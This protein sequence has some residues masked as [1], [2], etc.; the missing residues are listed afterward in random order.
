MDAVPSHTSQATSPLP[1]LPLLMLSWKPK[2]SA[3]FSLA[4]GNLLLPRVSIL[5]ARAVLRIPLE[6]FLP[7]CQADVVL[8]L[9]GTSSHEILPTP[10]VQFLLQLPWPRPSTVQKHVLFF[11]N[12]LCVHTHPFPDDSTA[13]FL[14]RNH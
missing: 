2:G 9:L 4:R 5:P 12:T 14:G 11:E 3:S 13:T 6:Q 7:C 1:S 8:L 10:F